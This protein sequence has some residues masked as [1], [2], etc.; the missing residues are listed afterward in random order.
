MNI[1]VT[2]NI[3]GNGIALL[4]KHHTVKI[5]P[6]NGPI[7]KKE[8]LKGAAWADAIVTLLTDK[9]DAGFITKNTHLKIIANYA[10]GYD[11]IDLVTATKHHIPVTNTPGVLTESV[12]E[13]A[14]ALMMALGK[15]L[16]E[17]DT[18]VRAKK[19]K[20]WNPWLL[21]GTEFDG[22]TVG[23]IGTGRIGSLFVKFA[24]ALNMHI[25]YNDVNRIPELEEAYGAQYVSLNTLLEESDVVSVHVP[26]LASTRHLLNANNLKRMKKTA[27]LIN[28]SRG[29]VIDEHA[30][31][32]ALKRKQL[33]G[34]GLD[35]YEFEPNPVPALLKMPNVILTPHI[36]SATVEARNEMSLLVAKNILAALNNQTP[37]SLVNKDVLS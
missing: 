30:L 4:K 21:L 6:Q 25:L 36:A 9:I 8:L 12:A 32:T 17:A 29:P 19:Y 33:A 13:H 16:R 18:F 26:L 5:A 20:G 1:F 14:I 27:F 31:A 3:P 2:R 10:V 7:S 37:P 28:T 22:K 24:K 15:R 34:A 35:V 11:N 23:V